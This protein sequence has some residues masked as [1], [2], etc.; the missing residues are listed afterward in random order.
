MNRLNKQVGYNRYK[1]VVIKKN[2]KGRER[3]LAWERGRVSG[4]KKA[5]GG[6]RMSHHSRPW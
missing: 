2:L 4:I 6:K 3:A 5:S 1:A